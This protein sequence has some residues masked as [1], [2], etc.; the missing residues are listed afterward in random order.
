MCKDGLNSSSDKENNE[1]LP[2]K[3]VLS[4]NEIVNSETNVKAVSGTS[5]QCMIT[6][7]P[8]EDLHDINT[9]D[10]EYLRHTIYHYNQKKNA[11][12]SEIHLKIVH[13]ISL[14]YFF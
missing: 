9:N 11:L 3:T 2:S 4:P 1:K 7:E 10:L 6:D 8:P 12:I 13:R 5:S 14:K